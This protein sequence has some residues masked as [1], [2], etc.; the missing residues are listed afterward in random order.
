[1]RGAALRGTRRVRTITLAGVAVLATTTGC[2]NAVIGTATAADISPPTATEAVAQSLVDLGE[3]GLVRYKGTLTSAG[4]DP[5]TYDLAAASTGE[6]A[7]SITIEGK[8]ATL[9]VVERGIYLKAAADFWA[10]LSGVASGA[11]KGTAVAD[12]WVKVPGGLIGVE[13]ADVFTPE[14]LGQNLSAHLSGKGGK[15]L[16]DGGERSDVAGAKA[17]KVDTEDGSVY[18]T[19]AAPH[20][21]VK[22]RLD[23]VGKAD[24][25]TVKKLDTTVTDATAESAKFYQDVAAQAAELAA[26][27]DVLTTVQEG[28]HTFEGCGAAS[29]SIV[30]QFT[31]GSKVAV[32]VSVRGN[33]VGDNAPLG[34]CD[35]VTAPVAPGQPGSAKCT[36]SSPEWV[37]FYSRA[38]SVPGNHPY[39]VEW[40]T[41]VLAD[42]PD[43]API[44]ARSKA[45]PADAKDHK[46]EGTHFVYSIVYGKKVWKYGVVAGKFWADHADQQLRACLGTT[47]SVCR[48]ELVTAAGDAVAAEGLLKQLVD[49]YRTAN[50]D[51]PSG[52]WAGCKR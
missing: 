26:P 44:T 52:Q 34:A 13:F 19:E 14:V 49:S 11:N 7:G 16:A 40:S 17:I 18:V 41:V 47:K 21:V 8:A 43:L 4:N 35:T 45:V 29:C 42:P 1:M 33:W 31:N 48:V 32:K 37:Q 2:S 23:R 20:G 50:G 28:T 46:T 38:N 9:L 15:T 24:P 6:I 51:C 3:A 10:T 30:V 5:V 12:R 27:V 25:T 22:A 39:S 36:V